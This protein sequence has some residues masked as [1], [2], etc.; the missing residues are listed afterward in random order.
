MRDG[1]RPLQLIA[2][3]GVGALIALIFAGTY[4]YS[5]SG[6]LFGFGGESPAEK[7]ALQDRDLPAGMTRCTFSDHPQG[8]GG[9]TQFDGAT[10][11]ATAVY[12]DDCTV[13]PSRRYAFSWVVE[14]D[15]VTAAVAAYKAFIGSQDCTIAH[16]CV[17]WGLGQNFN[18]NCG[19]A[20][21][22]NPGT[23]SCLGTWQRNAFMVTFQ[24]IMGSIDEAKKAVLEM[25]ARA[26]RS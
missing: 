8:K 17:D 5:T 20:Q 2:L 14:F 12:A 16:G 23:T 18:L 25:D 10:D 19:T 11:A 9:D 22:S 3:G 15:S 13:P 24:G 21:G 6:S 1:P 4:V 26:G 7:V